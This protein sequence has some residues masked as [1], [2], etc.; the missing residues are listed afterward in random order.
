MIKVF[1]LISLLFLVACISV[2][3]C[4]G[5]HKETYNNISPTT[6]Q[7]ET[8]NPSNDPQNTNSDN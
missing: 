1:T 4:D 2:Y 6:Q 5:E 3:E 8:T 7:S